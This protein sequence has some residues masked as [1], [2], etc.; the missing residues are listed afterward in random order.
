MFESQDLVLL[1]GGG[2]EIDDY[3]RAALGGQ[4]HDGGAVVSI[5]A[6]SGLRQFWRGTT[7]NDGACFG[8][9]L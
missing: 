1:H 2:W 7:L 8:G 9:L 3:V 4:C 6:C 5:Q